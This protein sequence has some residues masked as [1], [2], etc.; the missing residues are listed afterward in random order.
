MDETCV[1]RKSTEVPPCHWI[2]KGYRCGLPAT[3]MIEDSRL[4]YC[5]E[6]AAAVRQNRDWIY[7]KFEV[8]ALHSGQLM[9]QRRTF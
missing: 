1:A 5:D 3:V 2:I 6:H 7:L 4:A 9:A 8:V